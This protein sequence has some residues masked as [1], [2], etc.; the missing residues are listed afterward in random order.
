MFVSCV[1][2]PCGDTAVQSETSFTVTTPGKWGR[3]GKCNE[4]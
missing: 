1:K 2:V 4:R 3:L